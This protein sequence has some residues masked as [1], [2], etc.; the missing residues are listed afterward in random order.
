MDLMEL[1][2]SNDKRL[3]SVAL[4][5]TFDNEPYLIIEP[6]DNSLDYLEDDVQA[7]DDLLDYIKSVVINNVDLIEK[8]YDYHHY[9]LKGEHV[10]VWD[11][12][13]YPSYEFTI[14]WGNEKRDF[15][16]FMNEKSPLN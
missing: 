15:D 9:G 1:I 6:Y 5:V 16:K 13:S 4:S 11:L 7:H 10:F 12:L 2:G 8:Y 14:R 3:K